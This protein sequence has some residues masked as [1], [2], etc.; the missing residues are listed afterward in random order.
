[1][2]AADSSR[3]TVLMLAGSQA[4]AMTGA[5]IVGTTGAIVGSMPTPHKA[6]STLPIAVQMTGMMAF[7]TVAA[8]AVLWWRRQPAAQPRYAGS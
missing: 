1:M 7:G 8:R 3:R 4:L 6:L 2:A 5:S